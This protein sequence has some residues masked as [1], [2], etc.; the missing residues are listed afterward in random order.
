[1]SLDGKI[2]WKKGASPVLF[3][4]ELALQRVHEWRSQSDAILV[5]ARTVQIDN[6]SLTV[7]RVAGK[8][9]DRV[10]IDSTGITSTGAQV[11]SPKEGR[12]IIV[13]TQKK[14]SSNLKKL[15][16]KGAVIISVKP[17]KGRVDLSDAMKKLGALGIRSVMIEGGGELVAGALQAGIVDELRLWYSPF[18]VGGKETPTSVEGKELAGPNKMIPV[19][20]GFTE[21]VGRDFLVVGRPGKKTFS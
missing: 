3:S 19:E 15:A 16:Q 14:Q 11:F 12:V 20:I 5:S 1:M 21:T 6:P 4:D 2:T 9:P 17:A 8:N 18:I 7:R 10:I 13:T